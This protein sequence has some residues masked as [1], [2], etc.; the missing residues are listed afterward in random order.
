MVGNEKNHVQVFTIVYA[1]AFSAVAYVNVA[2]SAV[3]NFDAV[4]VVNLL[5]LLLLM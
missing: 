4:V 2:A 1:I 5:L 3:V